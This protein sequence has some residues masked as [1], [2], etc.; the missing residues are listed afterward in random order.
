MVTINMLWH[1]IF[2]WMMMIDVKNQS[3]APIN[4]VHIYCLLAMY[5]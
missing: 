2:K 3:H 5:N 1:N 4:E